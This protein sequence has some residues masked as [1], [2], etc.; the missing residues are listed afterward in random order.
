MIFMILAIAYVADEGI[1][2]DGIHKTMETVVL[3][4]ALSL[5]PVLNI[6]IMVAMII[7]V[8]AMKRNEKNKNKK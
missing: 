2:K 3:F 5:V 7:F 8:V 4:V 1:K 6:I